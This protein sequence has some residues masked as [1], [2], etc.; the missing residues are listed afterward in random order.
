MQVGFGIA[1]DNSRDTCTPDAVPDSDS[2][3]LP[4][5]ASRW[6]ALWEVTD[7]GSGVCR[8]HRSEFRSRLL[9][10]ARPMVGCCGCLE[11][12]IVDGRRLSLLNEHKLTDIFKD[13]FSFLL[14]IMY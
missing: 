4:S 6:A 5:A 11:S 1:V 14:E 2:L 8:S 9:V 13:F 3:Q 7:S 12:Q 10:L